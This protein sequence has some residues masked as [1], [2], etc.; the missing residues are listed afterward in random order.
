LIIS[1]NAWTLLASDDEL[2][3]WYLN[4]DPNHCI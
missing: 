1:F 4:D 3:P 2:L